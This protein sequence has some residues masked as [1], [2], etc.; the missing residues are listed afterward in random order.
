MCTRAML[1]CFSHVQVCVTPWTVARHALLSMGFSRQEYWSGLP[2]PLQMCLYSPQK[3][4]QKYIMKAH[5]YL[6]PC[7][8]S[9][10]NNQYGN[11]SRK[12]SK[13]SIESQTKDLALIK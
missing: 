4:K 12:N 6:V 7:N 5:L 2:S 8:F 1:S 13:Y 9:V 11:V 10:S 3:P